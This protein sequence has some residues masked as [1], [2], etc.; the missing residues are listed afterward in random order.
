MKYLKLLIE[1]KHTLDWFKIFKVECEYLQLGLRLESPSNAQNS[2]TGCNNWLTC[3]QRP[4]NDPEI[5]G[6]SI[7]H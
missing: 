1:I 2:E 4:L 3:G 5:D 7:E 6:G